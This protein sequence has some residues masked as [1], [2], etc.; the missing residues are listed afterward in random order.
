MKIIIVTRYSCRLFDYKCHSIMI[1]AVRSNSV[2]VYI[3]IFIYLLFPMLC[4][5]NNFIIMSR[6]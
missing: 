1:I 6:F 3:I 5:I 2:S 4:T